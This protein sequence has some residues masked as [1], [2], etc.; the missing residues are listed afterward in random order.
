MAP[1]ARAAPMRLRDAARLVLLV[2]AA[3]IVGLAIVIA[4]EQ[5][6]RPTGHAGVSAAPSSVVVQDTT[7]RR[8]TIDADLLAV[9]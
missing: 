2:A 1:A 6:A 5:P 7:D 3:R 4:F 8:L 9:T